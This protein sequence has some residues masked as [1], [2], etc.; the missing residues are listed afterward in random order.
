MS[1]SGQI[2]KLPKARRLEVIAKGLGLLTEHV[3][4]LHG[5]LLHLVEHDRR[6]GVASWNVK[7]S[8]RI[9]SIRRSRRRPS[10]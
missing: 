9:P 2:L 10:R 5:D 3:E 6:R 1:G 7:G 8:K 4:R